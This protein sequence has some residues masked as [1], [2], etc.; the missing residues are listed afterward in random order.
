MTSAIAANLCCSVVLLVFIRY[1]WVHARS[2]LDPGIY[3]AANLLLLYPT[4]SIMLMTGWASPTDH[5]LVDRIAFLSWLATLGCLGFALGYSLIMGRRRAWILLGPT[6][7]A[8]RHGLFICSLLFVVSLV[9]IVYKVATG[10]Y[11]SYLIGQHPIPAVTQPM[12]LLANLQWPAYL[13]LWV[14]W[15]Y[16]ARTRKFLLLFIL[17]CLTVTAYQLI[18]GSKTFLSLLLLYIIFAY[19]WCNRKVPKLFALLAALLIVSVVFP[20]A[21]GFREHVNMKYRALPQI[22]E[23]DAAEAVRAAV[24][25]FAES[26]EGLLGKLAADAVSALGRMNGVDELYRITE[27]VPQ[28]MPYRLGRGYAA[29][30]VNVIP[31]GVWP[32]KPVYSRG[33]EYGRSLGTITSVTPFPIG[34]AYWDF[35]AFGVPLAMAVWGACLALLTRGWDALYRAARRHPEGFLVATYFLTQIYW[36]AGGESY[37]PEVLGGLFQQVVVVGGLYFAVRALVGPQLEREGSGRW[38][39]AAISMSLAGGGYKCHG[40]AVVG[41]PAGAARRAP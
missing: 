21:H 4:R 24:P 9:G 23:L 36:I 3:F 15:F 28:L 10:D 20:F 33:A 29:V 41:H 6:E 40:R 19:Y 1:R 12:G 11:I 32:Q 8:A 13:G 7:R 27:M 34:E 30:V 35:G 14:L 26:H 16:G 25:R 39:R 22:T 17:V 37:M 18:Q 38:C 2:L 5:G 31:R